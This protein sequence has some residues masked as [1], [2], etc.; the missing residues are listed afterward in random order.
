MIDKFF[1]CVFLLIVK[2]EGL[3]RPLL[4]NSF[5]WVSKFCDVLDETSIEV[6]QA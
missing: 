5:K 1:K 2:V 4:E 6:A 3:G